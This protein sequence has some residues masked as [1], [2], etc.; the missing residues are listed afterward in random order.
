MFKYTL[1]WDK[2]AV[3]NP[4]L[5][6]NNRCDVKKDIVCFY[7]KQPLQPTNELGLNGVEQVKSNIKQIHWGK[8]HYLIM[9]AMK[10]K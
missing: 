10:V 8:V 1:V 7:D 2:V 4:M 6:K 5:A 9:V 3:T